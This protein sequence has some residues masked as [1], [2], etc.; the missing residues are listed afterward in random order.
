MTEIT[1]AD[2]D[3]L[4]NQT[5]YSWDTTTMLSGV[6]D[7]LEFSEANLLWQRRRELRKAQEEGASVEFDPPDQR[8]AASY[9]S[10]LIEAAEYRFDVSLSQSIRY[11][12]LVTFV[13]ALELCAKAFSKRLTRNIPDTPPGENENVHLLS[14]LNRLSSSD[15]DNYIDDL[16]RLVYV[17][18][19]VVHTAGFVERYKFEKEIQEAVKSL[20]GFSIWKEDFLGTSVASNK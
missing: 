1:Q 4:L 12:G 10:Q 16:R 20:K 13:T 19:C 17:R 8:L 5:F 11:S 15:F 9:R 2:L 14:F 18:N 6:V 7:F 3:R